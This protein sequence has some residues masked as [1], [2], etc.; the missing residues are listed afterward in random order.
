MKKLFFRYISGFIPFIAMCTCAF[1]QT[2]KF[3]TDLNNQASKEIA[4]EDNSR[5]R[6]K[7]SSK[8]STTSGINT[9]AIKDFTKTFK[10][11]A[12]ARWFVIN[13]GFLAEFN[14]DGITTKV[15]YDRKG[16]WIASIRNYYE[17]N[18]PRD[19]RHQVKSHYYDYNIYYVQEVTVGD[20]I[21]YLVKIEDN[22]TM[23]TI[24][25]LDGEMSETESFDK[26]K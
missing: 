15:F 3:K 25:V 21:A 19:I 13:D 12:D 10:K 2:S 11:S 4:Y 1:A 7:H 17:N 20:K 14:F 23:K 22:A 6:E 26:S 9:K 5:F 24:R 18:L 8:V 16:K